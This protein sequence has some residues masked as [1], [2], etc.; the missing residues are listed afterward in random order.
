[1]KTLLLLF[2]M[3]GLS[4]AGCQN[5]DLQSLFGITFHHSYEDDKEG[6]KAFRPDNYDFPPSR[7]RSGFRIEEGGTF[8]SLAIAPTDGIREVEG[9]WEVARQDPLTIEVT[10]PDYDNPRAEKVRTMRWEI[11][12]F[13]DSL[14]YVRPQEVNK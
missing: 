11:V 1:M 3:L 13:T 10:L 6:M 12:S 9:S 4:A 14:L 2:F 8:T 5:D 7:G